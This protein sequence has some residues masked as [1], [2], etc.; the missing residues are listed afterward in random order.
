[1]DRLIDGLTDKQGETSIP[2]STLW[3]DSIKSDSEI[4]KT[5]DFINSFTV[6]FNLS[7]VLTLSQTLSQ[8]SPGF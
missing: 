7:A 4:A 6:S 2:V 5:Q 1:M 8:P 3:V